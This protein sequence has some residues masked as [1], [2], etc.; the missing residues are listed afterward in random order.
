MTYD[1]ARLFIEQAAVYG[2]RPGLETIRELLGRMDNPQDK[3]QII[4]IAGTNGKGSTGAFIS[5]VL[6]AAGYKVGRYISPAVFDWR[7]KIQL[8]YSNRDKEQSEGKADI[9]GQV[10]NKD[11]V[12]QLN[13]IVNDYITED[14]VI[15]A[16]LAIKT[17]CEAMVRDGFNHPTVFELETAMAYIYL[18]QEKV[19]FAVIEIGMGGRLDATN[20]AA[21]PLCSVITS[22]SMDHMQ[23]L[24]DTIEQITRE[25]AGIIKKGVPAVTA[26]SDPKIL[27]VLKEACERMDTSLIIAAE[28]DVNIHSTSCEGTT[29][30]YK[31]QE[32]NIKLLGEHQVTN[33]IL[34][35]EVCHILQEKG[36]NISQEA[37]VTGLSQTVW[38]GRFEII[39]TNP[40]FIIDGAHN[41]DAAYKLYNSVRTYFSG[42]RLFFIMGMFADKEY[43]KVIKIMAPLAD[44]IITITAPTARAL[45]SSELAKA[46]REYFAGTII[47]AQ[48]VAAAIAY[49]DEH[50]R[51]DDVIVAF[52]SLSF[53]Q[54]ITSSS[55]R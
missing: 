5:W 18:L 43:N 47:D 10:A 39:A 41:E 1:E 30:N 9:W 2:S 3:L 52:G 35:V 44:T 40:Y 49:T 33:A 22:I 25:K 15:A 46:V 8:I 26:N 34:A 23:Y 7:E 31:G 36:Y 37:I 4:H 32:Y 55:E 20:V 11:N 38:K 16:T 45:P 13:R 51:P 50:V 48:T 19:D 12:N 27:T 21:Q 14:G 28:K 6:A 24:G 53:L 42:R 29:F 17:A 54:E